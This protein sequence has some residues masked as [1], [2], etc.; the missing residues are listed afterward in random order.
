MRARDV[1]RFGGKEV[2]VELVSGDK[3]TGV[4][5]LSHC[6]FDPK[7]DIE[8]KNVEVN[9]YIYMRRGVWKRRVCIEI[10]IIAIANI[11]LIRDLT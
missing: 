6:E 4:I 1:D 2:R 5:S 3:L 11:E 7:K 9:F 10:P 8:W